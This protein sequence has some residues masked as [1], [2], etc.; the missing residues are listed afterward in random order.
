[1]TKLQNIA[2]TLAAIGAISGSVWALGKPPF[3]NKIEVEEQIAGLDLQYQIGRED[4]L[5][6]RI[7]DLEYEKKRRR[8][9]L[10]PFMEKELRRLKGE[11]KRV[12]EELNR[13][14]KK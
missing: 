7:F 11:L 8:G 3:A 10:P 4:S 5:E 1:M 12:Q 14:R 13:L 9:T 2:G 6:R